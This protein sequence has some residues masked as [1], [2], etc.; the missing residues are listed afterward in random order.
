[1]SACV[2]LKSAFHPKY[3]VVIPYCT[4]HRA[5]I[6]KPTV[7][8]RCIADP[9]LWER[10]ASKQNGRPCT[11]CDQK[12]IYTAEELAKAQARK[13]AMRASAQGATA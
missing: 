7:C 10:M 9:A 2:K 4:E 11:N 1:M 12:I 6:H 8:E 13:D 3:Q 5:F